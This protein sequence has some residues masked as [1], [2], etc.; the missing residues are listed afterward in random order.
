MI[1]GLTK[2]MDQGFGASFTVSQP[3]KVWKRDS[4]EI[5]ETQTLTS[6]LEA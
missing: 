5:Q 6:H 3:V 4:G 2:A 1:D